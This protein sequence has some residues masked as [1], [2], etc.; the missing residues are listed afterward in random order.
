MMLTFGA[1]GTPRGLNEIAGAK[2]QFLFVSNAALEGPLF[3][4]SS[5]CVSELGTNHRQRRLITG[6]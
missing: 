1:G 2:A 3:H 5:G 4:D 6:H